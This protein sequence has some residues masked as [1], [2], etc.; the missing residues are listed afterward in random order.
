MKRIVLLDA[1]TVNQIAAGEVI[2]RPAS[3]VKELVENSLDA[4][5]TRVEIAIEGGGGGLIRVRDNGHGILSD[6][7]PL[8]FESHATSKISTAGDLSAIGTLG[9]R[10]EALASIAAVAKVELTSRPTGQNEGTRVRVEGGNLI[11]VETAGC[12]PGTTV[13]VTELFY[14]TP[15]RRKF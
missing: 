7:L 4:G 1:N 12:P 3:I 8:A 10:G 11:S 5:S 14:N 9:F 6:D 13:I 2:E 15:A